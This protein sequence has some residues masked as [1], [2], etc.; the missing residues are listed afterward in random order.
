ML[1]TVT[2]RSSAGHG[3]ARGRWLRYSYYEAVSIAS[4]ACV[5]PG[6]LLQE[7]IRD[8]QSETRILAQLLTA[9]RRVSPLLLLMISNHSSEVFCRDKTHHREQPQVTCMGSPSSHP[10]RNV[11]RLPHREDHLGRGHPR[12][13]GQLSPTL[14]PRVQ[15]THRQGGA[16]APLSGQGC[17]RGTLSDPWDTWVTPQTH[18]L[19]VQSIQSPVSAQTGAFIRTT[20]SI[21]SQGTLPKQVG[22]RGCSG[23]P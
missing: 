2:G 9:V 22:G 17:S 5:H 13:T 4:R 16:S 7:G 18:F 15:P 6:H 20:L 12:N 3:L 11:P 23:A 8:A 10:P 14:A 1:L 21:A 19:P